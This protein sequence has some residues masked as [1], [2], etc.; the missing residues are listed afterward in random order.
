MMPWATSQDVSMHSGFNKSFCQNAVRSEHQFDK[1]TT[2]RYPGPITIETTSL[3]FAESTARPFGG[4]S[5]FEIYN[6]NIDQI[7]QAMS[8]NWNKDKLM[9]E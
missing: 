3:E 8:K 5:Q 7:Y 6:M 9:F 4:I 1:K 2:P